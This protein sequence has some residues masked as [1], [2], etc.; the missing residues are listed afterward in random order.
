MTLLERVSNGWVRQAGGNGKKI[1]IAGKMRGL[2]DFNFPAFY[3]AEERLVVEGYTDLFNPARRDADTGFNPLG[4][5]GNEDLQS[6]GFNL[7]DALAADLDWI[8]RHATTIYLMAGWETSSGAQAELAVA[9]ALGLE[10]IY[11]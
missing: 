10:V 8:C 3:E 2:M 11:E 7:R 9:K 5:T 4:M 1:Y 6:L